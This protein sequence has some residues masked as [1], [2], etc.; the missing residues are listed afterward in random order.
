MLG[1]TETRTRD[2]NEDVLS[3]DTVRDI[4]RDDRARIATGRLCWLTGAPMLLTYLR[5]RA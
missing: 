3:D 4:S 1:Q 5:E 2:R